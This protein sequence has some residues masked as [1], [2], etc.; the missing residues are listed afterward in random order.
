M[1]IAWV[2]WSNVAVPFAGVGLA[3]V[4][5]IFALRHADTDAVARWTRTVEHERDEHRLTV[6]AW[7][8]VGRATARM[9]AGYPTARYIAEGRQ[10]DPKPFPVEQGGPVHLSQLFE[11]LCREGGFSAAALVSADGRTTVVSRGGVASAEDVEFARRAVRSGRDEVGLRWGRG[12]RLA[13]FASP[14]L[15]SASGV[16]IAAVVLREDVAA[17]LGPALARGTH[18]EIPMEVQIA[19]HR[20]GRLRSLTPALGSDDAAEIDDAPLVDPW[21]DDARGDRAG[22]GTDGS[23]RE[24]IVSRG[25]LRTAPWILVCSV[26]LEDVLREGRAAVLPLAV[27]IVGAGLGLALALSAR[28]QRRF[29]EQRVQ[30]LANAARLASALDRGEDVALFLRAD[31]MISEARGAV[32]S[33]Y[34]VEPGALVGRRLEDLLAPERRNGESGHA[35]PDGVAVGETVHQHADGRPVPVEVSLQEIDGVGTGAVSLARVRDV[36][37]RRGSEDRLRALNRLLRMRSALSQA[38]ATVADRDAAYA[39]TCRIATEDGAFRLA[40]VGEPSPDGRIVPVAVAGVASEHATRLT[41]RWDV[42]PT[43]RNPA[44]TALVERRTVTC[45]DVSPTTGCVGW[46]EATRAAGVRSSAAVPFGGGDG[47]TAAAVLVLHGTDP[48]AFDGEVLGVAE[49]IA[50]DV[51]GAVGRIAARAAEREADGRL[52]A[53]EAAHRLLFESNPSPMWVYDVETFR[54][55]RVNDAAVAAYGWTRDELKRMTVTELRPP[56]DRAR[57]VAH[58]SDRSSSGD[59]PTEWR[60]LRKD[61]TVFPVRILRSSVD[62]LGRPA[63]LVL[64]EDL[65]ERRRA[66]EATRMLVRAVEQSPVSIVVTNRAGDIEYVNPHFCAASGYEAHEVLGANPRILKSGRTPPEV[67]AELWRMVLAGRTWRG[68]MVNR[69]KDGREFTELVT[70]APVHDAAGAITHL[71]GVKEDLT[72]RRA[73]EA[74]ASSAEARF[75]QAQKLEAVGQLA[76]GVAHDFNNLLCVILGYGQ[77]VAS[78]LGREHP[79]A[80]KVEQVI[81][82]GRRAEALTRQ[83][84]AFSRRQVLKPRIV[85][86]HDVVRGFESMLRH[87]IGEHVELRTR[88]E[89]RSSVVLVDPGQLEQVLLNLTVNARD[90]MPGGGHVTIGT[91][92]LDVVEGLEV[93]GE[94]VRPGPW[95]VLSVEDDGTGM[96]AA[97]LGRLF[98]PF[99]TTKPTGRG[100]GLGLST[101]HGIVR[102]SGGHVGVESTLGKGTTFSVYLPRLTEDVESMA[103]P[104]VDL[105]AYV[106]H[107]TVLVVEDQDGVRELVRSWLDALGYDVVVASDGW[108]ALEEAERRTRPVDLLLTD[109][110]MPRLGGRAVAERLLARW[111][112]L[113]VV[114]MS[115]YTSDV[116]AGHG[117]LEPG[118]LLLEKPL[119]QLALAKTVRGALDAA[120]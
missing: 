109:V 62:F 20:D 30:S 75:L 1:R 31:G 55:L 74:R 96:D 91:R 72:D 90:A 42:P 7:L 86:L 18:L 66:E 34:G 92:S 119:S 65:T 15:A 61:G 88:F 98:E 24:L 87:L 73:M 68:E 114:Y 118:V 41:S 110:V 97:T 37:E 53:S 79:E 27:G 45:V 4:G 6:D 10:D 105:G 13:W 40:W 33:M 11:S 59:R 9:A 46:F 48:S 71:V 106:G 76:G 14:V 52:R 117:V 104:E 89:A 44:A 77:M 115:G 19:E 36:T 82:A 94:V 93:G 23:T 51:A 103:S 69:R 99:F 3:V 107:E 116:I 26:S 8:D 47:P 56:E 35:P 32:R 120:R 63:R 100:T 50:A 38:L 60:H 108:A 17:R 84:L 39:V 43:S 16:P 113:R 112:R 21:G 85:E 57:F 5:A 81:A 67:Y 80:G 29:A 12:D 101:V 78:A 102:Q 111:P 64:V 83:L 2:R 70:I 58:A 22:I 49:A 95:L 28:R 54:I 25:P